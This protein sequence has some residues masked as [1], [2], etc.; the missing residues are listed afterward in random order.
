MALKTRTRSTRLLVVTLVSV[1]LMIIT[2]DY[3]QGSTGPLAG[4]S[5]AA[6][7]VISPLQETVSKVT[8]P[9]GSFFS[10]LIHLPS[11]RA[12]NKRVKEENA[13]LRSQA[14]FA[15]SQEADL[16]ELQGL[17]EIRSSLDAPTTGASV[18]SS[19]VSNFEWTI[20]ID[21][22]SGS[23]IRVDMP[24]VAAAGLVGHVVTVTPGSAVVQLIIDPDSNVAGRLVESSRTG[25]LSGQGGGD[26]RMELVDP[27]T[28]VQ[29]DEAVVTAGFEIPGVA[30][31]LYP[32]GI[33]IGTVSRVLEDA[34]A[35][36]KFVTIRPAVDFSTL[37]FVLVVLSDGSG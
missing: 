23:G 6:L 19:G 12:E 10:T 37:Q 25:L 21:K 17:L 11:L 13:I 18:I 28:E 15:A 31:S 16:E 26:L 5:R 7:A 4:L 30:T 8:R 35:L 33:V 1:S 2:V 20:T 3:R 22:G 9:I 32:R 36:E 29:A 14:V 27:S 34:S 24:V